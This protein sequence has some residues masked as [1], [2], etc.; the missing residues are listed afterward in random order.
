[1]TKIKICGLKRIED[2]E[3]VNRYKPE[4]I[5]FVF[6]KSKRQVSVDQAKRFLIS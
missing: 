3:A 1:M 6:A 4:Y 2:I 5:G